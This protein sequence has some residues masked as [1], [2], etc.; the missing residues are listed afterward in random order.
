MPAPLDPSDIDFIEK[1]RWFAAR[2]NLVGTAL[3]AGL[4]VYLAW[5]YSA[6]P[7]L[8]NPFQVFGELEVG[9]IP[10]PTLEFMA[11][12]LPVVIW[13]IFMVLAV[14]IAFGFAIFRNERRYLKIIDRLRTK[15]E[16]AGTKTRPSR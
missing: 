13:A 10:Q 9:G 5:L 7:R 4:V 14:V 11:A 1:R 16:A 6:H 15:E 2:W 8:A 3:L 12:A